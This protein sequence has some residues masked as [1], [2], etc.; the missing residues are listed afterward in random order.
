MS[1]QIVKRC[2]IGVV[3]AL[4]ALVPDYKLLRTSPQGLELIADFEG[5]RLAPYQ[6][7]AGVWTN[8]VGHTAGVKPGSVI[9]EHQAASN[10]VSDVLLVEKRLA[11]CLLVAPPQ[12]VYDA[13]VSIGFNVGTGA[14][15]RST[16]VSF[17]NRQQWWQACDQLPR[18]VY[19]N[20][21]R[22]AGLEKRRERERAWCLKGAGK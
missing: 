15:C 21:V 19:V 10:L 8:G 3:L 12:H 9:T 20:G 22:S 5:C 11:A 18:W 16:M 6:C 17:I 13:L 2:L 14:I 1:A 7:S 4:A